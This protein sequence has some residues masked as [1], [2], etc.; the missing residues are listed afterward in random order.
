MF[1]SYSEFLFEA[2]DRADRII[3]SEPIYD[4]IKKLPMDGQFESL[5]RNEADAAMF[6]LEE[7]GYNFLEI[8]SEGFTF[9]QNQ[10]R[11]MKFGKYAWFLSGSDR[12]VTEN[13]YVRWIDY[14]DAPSHYFSKQ[15]K[16]YFKLKPE[17]RGYN[18]KKYGV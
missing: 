18:M 2:K 10:A 4:L 15:F 1:K 8:K 14:Q 9:T 16:D 11:K 13:I 7:I 12:N 3:T 17:K 6:Y 5:N